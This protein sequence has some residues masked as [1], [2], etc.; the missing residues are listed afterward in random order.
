MT[1]QDQ[2]TEMLRR[3][4]VNYAI[5]NSGA[6]VRCHGARFAFSPAGALDYVRRTWSD[7]DDE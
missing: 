3:A 2:F 1:D 6:E 7:E 5:E 4:G